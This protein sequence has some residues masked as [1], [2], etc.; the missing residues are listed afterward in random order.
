MSTKALKTY[1]RIKK[2]QEERA[3]SVGKTPIQT[4]FFARLATTRP[5]RF[6]IY[7]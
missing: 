7:R 5:E 6:R 3:E 2:I 4:I 1:E